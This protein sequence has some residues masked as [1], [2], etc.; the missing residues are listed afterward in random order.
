MNWID[1]AILTI[2][3]LSILISLIE[4]FTKTVLSLFAWVFSF[5]IA[6]SYLDKLAVL[7]T[8]FIPFTDTRL[9]LSLIILFNATFAI[10]LWVNYLIVR[11]IELTELSLADRLFGALLGSMRGCVAITFLVLLAGLSKLPSLD[12]WHH[13]SFVFNFQQMAILL[14]TQLP[15]NIA[16]QFNFKP[17][18]V[19]G[20]PAR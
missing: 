10:L 8:Q 19:T 18:P 15:P 6:L 13:S 4:G 7:L 12:E 11:S 2:I 17:V 9:G 16:T 20:S 1:S 5:H 14:C 3:F